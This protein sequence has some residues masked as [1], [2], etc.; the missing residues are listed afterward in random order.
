MAKVKR[1][2]SIVCVELKS[3]AIWQEALPWPF[4]SVVCC[5]LESINGDVEGS[6]ILGIDASTK[7]CL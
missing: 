4:V 1:W 7:E 6:D 5:L 3:R 2:S